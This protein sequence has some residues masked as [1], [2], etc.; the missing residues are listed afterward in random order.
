MALK[1]GRR[2]CN[3]LVAYPEHDSGE[4]CAPRD[5]PL[6]MEKLGKNPKA[7]LITIKGSQNTDDPCKARAYRGINGI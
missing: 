3:L 1:A 4:L 2:G 5:L 7:A 6:L